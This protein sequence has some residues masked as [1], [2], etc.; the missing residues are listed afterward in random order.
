MRDLFG[1]FSLNDSFAHVKRELT[2]NH[3]E[4]E[5]MTFMWSAFRKVTGMNNQKAMNDE[6]ENAQMDGMERKDKVP[7]A[8]LD[9]DEL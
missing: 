2:A 7:L 3:Y 4:N 9:L 1:Y 6:D 8:K 5:M